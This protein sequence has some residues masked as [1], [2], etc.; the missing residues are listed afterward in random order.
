MG[1]ASRSISSIL[2]SCISITIFP[3]RKFG[4]EAPR[5]AQQLGARLAPLPLCLVA[6]L[7]SGLRPRRYMF[8]LPFEDWRSPFG[9]DLPVWR[10]MVVREWQGRRYSTHPTDQHMLLCHHLR[11][12]FVGDECYYQTI[13]G[14]VPDLKISKKPRSDLLAGR[15]VQAD[16]VADRIQKCLIQVICRQLSSRCYFARKFTPNSLVLDELDKLLR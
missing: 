10:S 9:P 15:K 2:A 11:F 4:T 6:S 7:R 14:D 16:Q 12:R 5:A 3:A 13:L 8:N 1:Y